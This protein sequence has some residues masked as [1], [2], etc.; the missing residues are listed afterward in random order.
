MRYG[1]GQVWYCLLYDGSWCKDMEDVLNIAQ[2]HKLC[3]KGLCSVMG[4]GH[5]RF[6]SIRHASIKGV[7]PRH[8]AVGKKSNHAI[9][10]DD[11]RMIHFKNHFEYLHKLAEDRAVKVIKTM[12]DGER[13]RTNRMDTEGN[14]YLPIHMGY[15]NCYY[16]YMESL[17]Y[18]VTVGPNG[19]LTLDEEDAANANGEPD[20]VPFSTYWTKWK[21]L[22]P[23]MKVSHPAE[24]I[25]S[26]C[27]TFSNKHR[28][29][30][31]QQSAM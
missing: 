4:I 3:T 26:Y 29:L 25:C 2:G 9:K 15:R 10:T 27:Y 13:G 22:Y 20:F 8:K 6:Q 28:I 12:V 30:S 18:K 1:R 7:I 21:T 23:H 16:R 14:V 17:G 11:P 31:S 5:N 19:T 24:D